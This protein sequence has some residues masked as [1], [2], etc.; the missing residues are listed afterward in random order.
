LDPPA[1][2]PANTFLAQGQGT[3]DD[4]LESVATGVYVAD[5]LACEEGAGQL[6]L[7]AAAGRMIRGG[8]L[9]EP[10]KGVQLE[11]TLLGLLGRIDAVAGD[12]TW[13]SSAAHCR[14]GAHGVV[15]V[16]TGAPHVRF[17]DV[18]VTGGIS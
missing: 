4:L 1:P 3:L 10:V 15:P 16:S 5:V 12:F 14:D 13:D 11:G 17:V 8:R 9:A 2:R 6:V 18:A 7:R